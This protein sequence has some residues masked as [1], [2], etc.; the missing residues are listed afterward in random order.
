MA[1]P[2]VAHARIA[3]AEPVGEV[4]TRVEGRVRRLRD[5]RFVD[6][7]WRIGTWRSRGVAERI[8]DGPRPAAG[9]AVAGF[10]P[11]RR[12]L[13]RA[14]SFDRSRVVLLHA[15]RP[16]WLTRSVVHGGRAP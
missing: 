1:L 8:E 4:R 2:R 15:C 7:E 16:L 6:I 10:G 5:C 11:W 3:R 12:G 13:T 9:G 14:Q